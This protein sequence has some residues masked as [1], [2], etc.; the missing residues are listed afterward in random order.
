MNLLILAGFLGS[1]KTTLL[2]SIARH[3]CEREGRKIAIVENEVGK[4]GVDDSYLKNEGLPVREILSGCICCTLQIDLK[5]TLLELEREYRPDV[6]I[7]EPSGVAGP[8]QVLEALRGYG[9]EISSRCIVAII[10]GKRFRALKDLGIPIITD[11]LEI[12]DIVAINKIDL[13]SDEELA[14]LKAR[15]LPFNPGGIYIPVSA[16]DQ[17]NV[18]E[19]CGKIAEGLACCSVES[20][21]HDMGD[22]A[23]HEE[24]HHHSHAPSDAPQP[25]VH[26][27]ERLLNFQ[28]PQSHE[29]VRAMVSGMLKDAAVEL[30]KAGCSAIGHVK[31]IVRDQGDGYLLVSTT[32]FDEEPSSKGRV[33][34]KV[35]EAKV[36][37]NAIVYGIDSDR[38]GRIMDLGLS[39][40]K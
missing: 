5:R 12:A 31:A 8:K 27:R 15:L 10:D 16:L 6:V 26:A 7:L 40:L 30:R 2:L 34:S 14:D 28:T 21:T 37:L 19:L 11:G 1:G 9:G 13:I 33:S 18:E 3:L 36:T 29:S 39:E 22:P 38:L 24:A 4:V 35:T 32:A 17:T 20:E 25:V 23:L